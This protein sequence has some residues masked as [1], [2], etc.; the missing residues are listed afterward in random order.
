MREGGHQ[1]FAS[2]LEV[3]VTVMTDEGERFSL[4]SGGF[5]ECDLWFQRMSRM[6]GKSGAPALAWER[7]F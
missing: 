3:I 4:G 2:R 7:L 5:C 6:G 1:F